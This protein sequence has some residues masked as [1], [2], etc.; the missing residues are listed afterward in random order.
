MSREK[1]TKEVK[2][3]KEAAVPEKEVRVAANGKESMEKIRDLLFGSQVRDVESSLARLEERL[4]RELTNARDEFRSRMDSLESF[5]RSELETL[6]KQLGSEKD[7]R[8]ESV[9]EVAEDLG[10]AV[11]TFDQKAVDLDSKI[12]AAAK[13]LRDQL[14]SQSK[15]LT[16]E[17]LKRHE[18]A[19]KTFQDS[20]NQI[21]ADY[22]DRSDLSRLFT[23]VAVRLDTALADSLVSEVEDDTDE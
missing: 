5:V 20:A 21:R 18:E 16:D 11:K 13:D 14:H 3:T 10:S 4:L 7:E 19:L 2:E 9:K 17:A 23:E 12:Q 8:S 6:S 15:R 1:E 22:V